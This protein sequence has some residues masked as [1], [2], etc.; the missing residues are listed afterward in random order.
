MALFV[1]CIASYLKRRRQHRIVSLW[2]ALDKPLLF[3]NHLVKVNQ[4]TVEANGWRIER[5][6]AFRVMAL[7]EDQYSRYLPANCFA[8]VILSGRCTVGGGR[9]VSAVAGLGSFEG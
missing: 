1:G 5:Q 6:A 2:P 3:S 7:V 9:A 4:L 8:A